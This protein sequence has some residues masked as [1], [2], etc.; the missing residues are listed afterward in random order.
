MKKRLFSLVMAGMMAVSL[1]G[2]GGSAASGEKNVTSV[3]ATEESSAENS[4]S[5][6]SSSAEETNSAEDNGS[7]GERLP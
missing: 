4:S 5:A 7:R 6:E 3:A 2:C 1:A